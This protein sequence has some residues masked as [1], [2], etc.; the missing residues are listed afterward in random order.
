MGRSSSKKIKKEFKDLRKNLLDLTLRNQLLNFKDRNQTLSIPYQSPTNVYKRLV[1]QNKK[2]N[3]VPK[4]KDKEKSSKWSLHKPEI[5]SDDKSLEVNLTPNELQKKLFYINNQSKTMLQE[6][7]YNILYMAIGFLRWFDKHKPKKANFAPLILI[8]VAM[9][10]KQAGNSFVIRWTGEDIQ[11]NISLKT[12]LAEDGIKIPDFEAKNY[13]EAPNQYMDEIKKAIR[14]KDNWKVTNKVALG[15]FS[16]TKFI[17]YNDLNPESWG[18]DVD[19]TNH[20]LI[21]AIFDPSVNDTEGFDEN[22]VDKINYKDMYQVLD[23][24]S[25]QISVIEDVKA[26]R[27]LVVE[28]PPG[29]GKSQTIVNL[30]AELIAD[31]K[32]VLFVSEKMAALEV[33]KD[34]LTAVG[35]GKYILELHSHKTRRKKFIK[36]LKKSATVRSTSDKNIDRIIRKLETIKVQLDDYAEIIHKPLYSVGL[37]AFDLYG[38]KEFAEEYFKTKGKILPLVRFEHP[39]DLTMKDLDDIVLSLE[40]LAELHTTINKD[41]PWSYCSPKSLLPNDLR[42]IQLLITDSSEALNRFNIEADIAEENFG[43]KKAKN[44]RSLDKTIKSLDFLDKE[45]PIIDKDLLN[46]PAWDNPKIADKLINELEHYQKT[47]KI[48]DKFNPSILNVD[49]DSLISTIEEGAHKKFRIFSKS[50]TKVVEE[51]YKGKVPGDSAVLADL[52]AVKKFKEEK[53]KIESED[54]LGK[55]YFSKY[56]SLN[57]DIKELRKIYNWMFEL[58]QYLKEDIFTDKVFDYLTNDFKTASIKESLKDYIKE[59]NSFR[60]ELNKLQT[61]LKPNTKVIFKKDAED[62]LFTEW[63]DQFNKWNGHFSSLHLWSQYLNTKNKCMDSEAKLFINTIEKRNIKKDD[64]NAL[65]SGNFADSLLNKLFME[66]TELSSFVGELH[67]NRIKEFQDLDREILKLNRR[68]VFNKLNKNIPKIYGGASDP[69]AKILAGEFTRK[70]GHLPVRTLLEKAGTIIK[71]IKPVFMM[72]P[73]SIAQYLDPTNPKLQFDVVIFDEASQVKP[74]DALGAFMRGKTAVVM[75]DT[76]Q[77][78]PT[79]FFDQIAEGDS[80]EEVA[81]A[82]DM[83]S[84]L[85]LC[86]LSFPVKMLKW[87]YRSRHE[88][89]IAVSNKEFYDNQLLV[90]PSPSHDDPELGLKFRYCPNTVYERGEGSYNRG[91]AKEV[92]KEIFKHFEKY[93]DSKS[94]GVGTFSVAQRNAILEEL[95]VERKNH[96]ELEPLFSENR[97]DRFF[98]KNLETIQGDERDVIL[99]SVGYG[100]DQNRKMS[101]NF[102]P[103]NQDGGERRLN[104]LVTRAKEKCVVFSNFRSHD[105]HLTANPPFGV[106]ALKEFLEYAESLTIGNIPSEDDTIE[107]FEEGIY[108]FLVDNGYTVDKHVGCAGFRVD[109]AIVDDDNPGRYILGITTDGKMYASSKVARDR[110]RLREQVLDGLGWKLY[111]LWSTDWYRNCEAC[112]K[113]LLDRVQQAKIDI[114]ED[115]KKRAE[116]ER[117]FQEKME[118]EKQRRLEEARRLKEEEEKKALEDA[119]ETTNDFVEVIDENTPNESEVNLNPDSYIE[120]NSN[121]DNNSSSI[122]TKED[123]LKEEARSRELINQFSNNDNSAS[124]TTMKTNNSSGN[125]FI[126]K[127][128]QDSENSTSG[129]IKKSSQDND[130]NVSETIRKNNNDINKTSKSNYSNTSNSIKSEDIDGNI[131]DDVYDGLEKPLIVNNDLISQLKKESEEELLTNYPNNE[132]YIQNNNQY[133]KLSKLNSKLEKSFDKISETENKHRNT[134]QDIG[135]FIGSR[136]SN[137]NKKDSHNDINDYNLENNYEDNTISNDYNLENEYTDNIETEYDN[138]DSI[139]NNDSIQ[140]KYDNNSIESNEDIQSKYDDEDSIQVNVNDNSIE[141]KSINDDS[142]EKILF[143]DDEYEYVEVPKNRKLQDGEKVISNNEMKHIEKIEEEINSYNKN[144]AENLNNSKK[145]KINKKIK[146][147]SSETSKDEIKNNS[148]RKMKDNTI[149][150]GKIPKVHF[151]KK[152]NEVNKTKN[153]D[154]KLEEM[155]DT[156]INNDEED[157]SLNSINNEEDSPLNTYSNISENKPAISKNSDLNV[158]NDDKLNSITPKSET[159]NKIKDIDSEYKSESEIGDLFNDNNEEN[160]QEIINEVMNPSNDKSNVITEDY[161]SNTYDD[162]YTDTDFNNPLR[163]NHVQY[164]IE[165]HDDESIIDKISK[166]KKELKYINDSLKEIENSSQPEKVHV[167]DRSDDFDYDDYYDDSSDN[168][169]Y[170]DNDEYETVNNNQNSYSNEYETVNSNQNTYLNNQNSYSNEYITDDTVINSED[171]RRP[172]NSKLES[173]KLEE[174]IEDADKDYKKIEKE[175]K[176][177]SN[178]LKAYDNRTLPTKGKSMKDYIKKYNEFKDLPLKTQDDVY[179]KPVSYI[180]EVI[181]QIVDVE[182]PIH[183]DIIT[184]R[185]K[186]SSGI[187]RAG[188]KLKSKV[189]DGIKSAEKEGLIY[190]VD[191]F[192]YSTKNPDISV[193]KRVK[194]NIDLISEDEIGANIKLVLVFKEH[195]TDKKLT[196][197]VARNFGF[198]STSKKTS[199]KINAV[200]DLMLAKGILELVQGEI[201]I[202]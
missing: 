116:E 35:L 110:D 62:V 28:G 47:S 190:I 27:N 120:N 88:S 31:G 99:I 164:N 82:N 44:L 161:E 24:D 96:P 11:T 136:I 70:S 100:F 124:E 101:L 7:G 188:S 104:V 106:R 50:N 159:K 179:D 80:H 183:K 89:L 107:P 36:E 189:N 132:S 13:V 61:T 67:E 140:S 167:I 71:K 177:E 109:L 123:I 26:G 97:P 51:F 187:K 115:D 81:S 174:V 158:I 72:S 32:T 165:D 66:S 1:L 68:R 85:H 199:K 17:M 60:H 113:H 191:D 178:G 75:G 52:N 192:L 128:N 119:R 146:D 4:G 181:S 63:V 30:I 102:G 169:E 74:E 117:K 58:K 121:K 166:F 43:I 111:H 95:E 49:I 139:E 186:E 15:F 41:N 22:D 171:I 83:E 197:A 87:H 90:Y 55:S 2:M 184:K 78:P 39:E 142:E 29:T 134:L 57:A 19:L 135:S 180:G 154:E 175:R 54:T 79:S 76:Q 144:I 127:S 156:I 182:G 125:S 198:K 42:E 86:K 196:R 16:F 201:Q 162:Y 84:I 46:S 5:F 176:K 202:K 194:P 185:I 73:L 133:E 137:I 149:E 129:F 92:V 3:F 108:T 12:K 93:G 18:D 10:R 37:S 168:E 130:N 20:P 141:N 200:I 6:Q 91:E 48:L 112:K 38:R 59:R 150:N 152:F 138:E 173:E 160:D 65:V 195:L 143:S 33:V 126:N 45:V 77:L 53:R 105:M 40:N 170:Y 94:L 103:L 163:K 122:E 69:E 157:N 172:V 193:R 9:E 155:I 147:S 153:S 145:D 148:D 64:V 56:W 14:Y 21:Q 114:I 118:A 34:R 25:S 151:R 23:A 8:P 98:V 131:E